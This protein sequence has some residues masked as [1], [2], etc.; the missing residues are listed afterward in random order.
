MSHLAY[1]HL[2]AQALVYLA[3]GK[4]GENVSDCQGAAAKVPGLQD[5]GRLTP[6]HAASQCPIGF[7]LG[8]VANLCASPTIEAVLQIID[9]EFSKHA[10]VMHCVQ[11]MARDL[12][13]LLEALA[14]RQPIYFRT[15]QCMH[16]IPGRIVH[17]LCTCQRASSPLC[18]GIHE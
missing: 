18:K 7:C 5:A 16:I 8:Y 3:G 17:L 6:Q 12:D 2:S 11:C 10:P 4:P 1:V 13:V 14:E 9:C 15:T